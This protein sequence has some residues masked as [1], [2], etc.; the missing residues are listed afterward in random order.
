M[1]DQP[2]I[3]VVDDNEDLL[4]TLSLILKRSG[5]CV[6][7]A[8]DGL[9]AVDK[10]R[11]RHFDVALM[12]I[13]MPR[14]NGVEAFRRIREIDPGAR[15]ILMTAYYEEELI[16]MALSEGAHSAVYKPIDIG[17]MMGLI[18]EAAS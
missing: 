17:H 3:L 16:T 10:F 13:L 15:V 4:R 6:D 1:R 18:K 12:D 7:T 5:Y 14:M 9:S 11:M 8:D 2:S